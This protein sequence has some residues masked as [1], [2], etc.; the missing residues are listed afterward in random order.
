MILTCDH[1]GTSYR[2]EED[3]IQAAGTRVRCSFCKRLWIVRP[4]DASPS[5]EPT[6][7]DSPSA[8]AAALAGSGAAAAGTAETAEPG[9]GLEDLTLSGLGIDGYRQED[10]LDSGELDFDALDSA[11][12]ADADPT[13]A[14]SVG[15]EG[16]DISESGLVLPELESFLEGED[17]ADA[18]TGEPGSESLSLDDLERM[19]ASE[20]DLVE[21]MEPESG[22]SGAGETGGMEEI[23]LADLDAG[24]EGDPSESLFAEDGEDLVLDFPEMD[25]LALPETG[26][27]E[28][29]AEI[30]P[31]FGEFENLFDDT[32]LSIEDTSVEEL[33]LTDIEQIPA[34]SDPIVISEEEDVE[35]VDLDL[36]NEDG[37]IVSSGSEPPGVAADS[38]AADT[39]VDAQEIGAE[40]VDLETESIEDDELPLDFQL[41]PE[42]VEEF[43]ED[44]EPADGI[45]ASP[46]GAAPEEAEPTLSEEL[47]SILEEE[48]EALPGDDT[49]DIDLAAFS[50]DF[51]EEAAQEGAVPDDGDVDFNLELSPE[52]EEI[53]SEEV[54]D[55]FAVEETEEIDFASVSEPGDGAGDREPVAGEALLPPAGAD[56]DPDE[57]VSGAPENGEGDTLFL[58]EADGIDDV[59]FEFEATG[60]PEEAGDDEMVS[61]APDDLLEEPADE[62]EL[63]LELELIGDEGD[64]ETPPAD[65]SAVLEDEA[66]GDLD[67]STLESMLGEEDAETKAAVEASEEASVGDLDLDLE[68]DD[69]TRE[70]PDGADVTKELDFSDIEAMLGEAGESPAGGDEPGSEEPLLE[71]ELED[72]PVAEGDDEAGEVDETIDLQEIERLLDVEDT[73]DKTLAPREGVDDLELDLDLSSSVDDEAELDLDF[74]IHDEEDEVSTLFDTSES[75]DLKLELDLDVDETGTDAEDETEVEP[76]LAFEALDSAGTATAAAG[77]V[78]APPSA[79][80]AAPSEESLPA[81]PVRPKTPVPPRPAR[82]GGPRIALVL[83]LLIA[84]LG[85]G[86]YYLTQF[87][88]VRIPFLSDLLGGKSAGT[89]AP[90]DTTLKGYFVENANEGPLYVIEGAVRNATAGIS[91]FIEVTGRVYG[92][93]RQMQRAAKAFCGNVLSDAELENLRLAEIRDRLANRRGAGNSN[94]RVEPGGEIPFMVVFGSLPQGAQLE[95]FT[96]EVSNSVK[97]E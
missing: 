5:G 69:L 43:D 12:E 49:E 40:T 17:A 46:D 32:E 55:D 8:A 68:L 76:D 30:E 57:A 85:G 1:C 13:G 96:V 6:G 80:R 47:G 94:V 44:L 25:D 53:F 19:L 10:L 73:T 58:D 20:G 23:A 86:G 93:N 9:S 75:D 45:L 3:R 97:V 31:E 62:G 2:L 22:D 71:L 38:D 84:L 39:M 29:D 81:E 50:A 88:D 16:D 92:D 51:A 48:S 66:D 52:L 34:E 82:S 87:T 64:L 27:S 37:D 14:F 7:G 77:A 15:D 56:D 26:A 72:G 61:I 67:L 79:V 70:D 78:A 83:L 36:V 74:D 91:S 18:P 63:D 59:K 42:I 95:E 41:E 54:D 60:Q 33:A 4:E 90:V 35:F 21:D 89:L 65:E 11:P 24:E 28:T